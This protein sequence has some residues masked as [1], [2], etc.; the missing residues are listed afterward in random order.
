MLHQGIDVDP[1]E[2]ITHRAQLMAIVVRAGAR[3]PGT[4]FFTPLS[5]GQQV[6]FSSWEAGTVVAPHR[7]PGVDRTPGPA[8]EVLIV[9]SGIVRVELHS[10]DGEQVASR[11]LSGGDVIVLVS[12]GHG[13]EAIEAVEA[14]LVRQGPSE[15]KEKVDF[16]QPR[17]PPRTP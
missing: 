9:Q 6:A 5:L 3:R 14:V 1:V 4:H 12:G 13:I 17:P 7:H 16:G 11:D 2:T 8:V 15:G 10:D